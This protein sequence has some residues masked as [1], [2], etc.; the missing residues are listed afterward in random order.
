MPSGKIDKPIVEDNH[1]G[2]V[3][4][5]YDPREEGSHELS[6]KFNGESVQGKIY[7]LVSSKLFRSK[8]FFAQVLRLSSMSIP[9]RLV[10][11]LP[12]ALV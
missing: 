9:F 3:S 1:D 5:H 8:L 10:S 6:L 2:T 7:N 12:T 11:L 4:I